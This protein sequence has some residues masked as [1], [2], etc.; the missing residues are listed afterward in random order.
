MC[1]DMMSSQDSGHSADTE[2]GDLRKRDLPNSQ[3]WSLFPNRTLV[4][5]DPHTLQLR[6]TSHS[7]KMHQRAELSGDCM[8][9]S[10]VVLGECWA[11]W[12]TSPTC[13]QASQAAPRVDLSQTD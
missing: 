8:L 4:H 11:R 12:G 5:S 7:S 3:E 2:M 1:W 10:R 9:F 6:G 13:Q